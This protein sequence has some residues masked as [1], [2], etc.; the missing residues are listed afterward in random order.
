MPAVG[1]TPGHLVVSISSAG[2]QLLFISDLA[3]HPLQVERPDWRMVF[4][5]S[6][7]QAAATRR[8]VL[9]GAAGEGVLVHA[10]HFPFPG[11]GHVVQEGRGLRWKPVV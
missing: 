8:R 4:D 1:H 7:D 11:L 9:E 10:F 3:A 6:P 2:E 5:L